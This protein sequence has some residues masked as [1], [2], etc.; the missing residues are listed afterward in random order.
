MF[1]V[2]VVEHVEVGCSQ[3]PELLGLALVVAVEAD[4]FL[5]EFSDFGYILVV[6]DLFLVVR[7][8]QY[9]IFEH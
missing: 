8:Q 3:F 4:D 2:D 6:L 7:K 5:N 1:G 9:F